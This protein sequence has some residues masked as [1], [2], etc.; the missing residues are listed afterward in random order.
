VTKHVPCR[1]ICPVSRLSWIN[2]GYEE[3]YEVVQHCHRIFDNSFN[4]N[5]RQFWKYIRAKHKDFHNIST[6]IV[7]G[8]VIPNSKSKADAL[9][10]YLESGLSDIPLMSGNDNPANTLPTIP[11]ITFSVAEIQHQLSLLDANKASGP[12]VSLKTVQMKYLQCCKLYLPS[13]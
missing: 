12:E 8:K 11:T 3:V 7:D 5:C 13:H 4:G 6:L 1:T 10:N 9:N 2:R